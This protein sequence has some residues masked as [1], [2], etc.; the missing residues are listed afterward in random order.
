M[1][2][3]AE[4]PPPPW[5]FGITALPYGVYG[6]FVSTAMPY[7]LR[8]AGLEVDRIAEISALTLAPAVWYFLWS[9]LVDVGLRRRSWLI[10]MSGLS[11]GCMLAALLLPLPSRIGM[12]GALLVAGTSLNMLVGAANGGLMATLVPDAQRGRAA[13]WYQAGNVGGGALGAGVTLSLARYLSVHALASMVALMVFVPSLAALALAEPAVAAASAKELIGEMLVELA[14]M[15]RSR[16]SLA[17]LAIFASPMGAS[18]AANLFSSVGTDYHASARTVI[19]IT[20]LLGGITTTIGSLG[21]GWLSDRIPRR[22]AYA[23]AAICSALCAAGMMIAL[24]EPVFAVGASMYLAAQGLSFAA[25]SALALELIGPGGRSAATRY[26]LYGA[27]SNL[28]IVYM[29]WL[30]GQGYKRFGVRGLMGAD[31]LAGVAAVAIFLVLIRRTL[32]KTKPPLVVSS[33]LC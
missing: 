22:L 10:L 3:P 29:T 25:Y 26:T 9:P 32:V 23:V 11:A 33:D 13:G 24:N 14:G 2:Y 28:P 30:D 31:C 16:R 27:F 7:L 1:P 8:N 20:G 18:A 19:W 4:R 12:F 5:L 15:F 21:G 17:G 6:G